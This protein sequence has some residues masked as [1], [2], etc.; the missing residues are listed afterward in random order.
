MPAFCLKGQ[1]IRVGGRV[2]RAWRGGR[3]HWP[4]IAGHLSPG[5]SFATAMCHNPLF[6]YLHSELGPPTAK[7][8][9]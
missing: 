1:T 3:P 6:V 5:T 8:S 7:I 9:R 4:R 2:E